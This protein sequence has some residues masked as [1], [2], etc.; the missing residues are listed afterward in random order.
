MPHQE[1]QQHQLPRAEHLKLV[2]WI[3]THP[4]PNL[5]W[6]HRH[7]YLDLPLS[8]RRTTSIL[9]HLISQRQWQ[10]KTKKITSSCRSGKEET[11]SIK[12][13]LFHV[14]YYT[15]SSFILKFSEFLKHCCYYY[16][17]I[18]QPLCTQHGLEVKN[19]LLWVFEL[20]YFLFQFIFKIE[21]YWLDHENQQI[22]VI[23][24]QSYSHIV[25][26]SILIPRHIACLYRIII[27]IN[28][29]VTSC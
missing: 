10:P 19:K 15:K 5:L 18:L 29:I 25:L 13:T 24:I 4:L 2:A 17:T 16:L 8:L 28:V 9:F 7:T 21:Y 6:L 27:I 26:Y 1:P 3:C 12:M 22:D 23:K 11:N 20:A 14:S